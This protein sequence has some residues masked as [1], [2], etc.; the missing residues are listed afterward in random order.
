MSLRKIAASFA[1][2]A[3]GVLGLAPAAVAAGQDAVVNNNELVL[4]YNSGLAGSFSDFTSAQT[5]LA[6]YTFIKS[7]LAG[8]GQGVAN[9]AASARNLKA[10]NARI[11]INTN[12]TGA[13]DVVTSE[14]SRNLSS[15]YNAN[16]SF[17]WM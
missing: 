8:Y 5:N 15:A 2:A 17:R 11:Y 10:S 1:V 16:L 9:N 7:G 12:F 6:G 14:S 13:Y 4:Y 3:T